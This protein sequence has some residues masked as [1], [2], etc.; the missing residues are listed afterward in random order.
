MVNYFAKLGGK[1]Y[2][3]YHE[4]SQITQNKCFIVYSV[5]ENPILTNIIE[6]MATKRRLELLYVKL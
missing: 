1:W 6:E 3:F 5:I 2:V 4:K